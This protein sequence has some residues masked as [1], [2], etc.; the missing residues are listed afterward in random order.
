MNRY[1]VQLTVS[2]EVAKTV[3]ADSRALSGCD[4]VREKIIKIGPGVEYLWNDEIEIT[5][6]TNE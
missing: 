5:G 6:V 4:P 2:V 1:R 3:K